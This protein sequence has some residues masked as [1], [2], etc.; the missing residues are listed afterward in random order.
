MFAWQL[1]RLDEIIN[2]I[3][4][5]AKKIAF[6]GSMP[7]SEKITNLTQLIRSERERFARMILDAERRFYEVTK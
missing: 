5:I 3:E 7:T 4:D 1:N 6:N 2:E